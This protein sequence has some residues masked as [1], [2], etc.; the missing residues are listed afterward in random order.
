[1]AIVF[2]GIC[3]MR[4]FLLML[5]IAALGACGTPAP[6]SETS[7]SAVP[8]SAV[9][10]LPMDP[11]LIQCDRLTNPAALSAASN[12]AL[13][14]ARAGGLSGRVAAVPDA[15]TLS[16]NLAQYCSANGGDTVRIAASQ[17]GL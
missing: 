9:F 15:A 4:L 5:P 3:R 13:G 7:I 12:W 2:K 14:Q 10:D 16:N 1:L 8:A 17:L 6:Q 11:G